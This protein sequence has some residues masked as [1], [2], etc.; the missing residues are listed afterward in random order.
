MKEKVTSHLSAVASY[1][2]LLA[3]KVEDVTKVVEEEKL[4]REGDEA[5]DKGRDKKI[6]EMED[7]VDF[8]KRKVEFLLQT[9]NNPPENEISPPEAQG[10]VDKTGTAD[11][12]R[13][14]E[15]KDTKIQQLSKSLETYKARQVKMEKR[16]LD[17]ENALKAKP[18]VAADSEHT[19]LLTIDGFAEKKKN[20]E[21]WNGLIFENEPGLQ[22][23]L[24]LTVWPNG[25]QEGKNTHVSMWLEQ[26]DA[27]NQPAHV[28]VFFELLNQLADVS[29]IQVTCHFPIIGHGRYIGAISN[30]LVEHSALDYSPSKGTQ[31]LVNNCLK[32]RVFIKT[33]NN[34]AGIDQ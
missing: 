13:K 1:A 24:V 21:G 34:H 23:K 6:K 14:L 27:Q 5:K 26:E 19:A 31:Y 7:D 2:V 20:K 8:L 25:Q 9:V 33:L 18:Q 17:I 11:L 4:K 15:E 29:H 10:E 30:T 16:L 28:L 32:V 3:T 12:V 22:H